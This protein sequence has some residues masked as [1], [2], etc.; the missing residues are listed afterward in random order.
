[1]PLA[2][3]FV[4]WLAGI[5]GASLALAPGARR[6]FRQARWLSGGLAVLVALVGVGW[7]V[8]SFQQASLASALPA[9][10]EY[11]AAP[12]QPAHRRGQGTGARPGGLDS[13]C[14]R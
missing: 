5:G 4:L 8:L 2:S 14:P 3:G 9:Q 1:M 7:A 6:S 13:R 11:T 10:V 12:S